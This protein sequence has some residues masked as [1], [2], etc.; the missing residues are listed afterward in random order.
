MKR[1]HTAARVLLGWYLITPPMIHDAADPAVIVGSNTK[2]PLRKW[3]IRGSFGNR[4]D[5]GSAKHNRQKNESIREE[6]RRWGV[7]PTPQVMDVFRFAYANA[8]CVSNDDPRLK[9]N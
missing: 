7:E 3:E 8:Q 1:R 2:T 6:L 4:A 5:C 9:P